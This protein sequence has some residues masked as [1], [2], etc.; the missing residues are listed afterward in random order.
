M[1]PSP[2]DAPDCGA[3]LRTKNKRRA[4]LFWIVVSIAVLAGIAFRFQHADRRQFRADESITA[5]RVSGHTKA[6]VRGLFDGHVYSQGAILRFQRVDPTRSPLATVWSIASEEPQITPLFFIVDREWA[7]VAGSSIASLRFPAVL[8]SIGAIAAMYWLCFELTGSYVVGGIG[9]ALMSL[10]P[11]FVNYGAQARQYSLWAALVALTSAALLAAF[12]KNSPR[13]WIFYSATMTLALYADAL[14]LFLL[15]AHTA[16][17]LCYHRDRRSLT[18]FGISA[19]IA[20]LFFLPW[21]LTILHGR[22]AV[23][24]DMG[25]MHLTVPLR[26]F[27]RAWAFNIAAVLFDAEW[28]NKWLFPFAIAALALLA[29]SVYRTQHDEERK[30]TWFLAAIAIGAVLP[31]L[32]LD[33]ATHSHGSTISRYLIPLWIAL[34][35]AVAL[36]LGRGLTKNAQALDAAWLV[37]FGTVLVIEG[38]S[39]AINSSAIVWWDNYDFESASIGRTIAASSSPLILSANDPNPLVLTLSHYVSPS[40]RF[41]LFMRSPPFPLHLVDDTFLLG[42]SESALSALREARYRVTRVPIPGGRMVALYRVSS[43]AKRN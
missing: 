7:A 21:M 5:L 10:S 25:W 41:L 34:L 30:K 36:L 9:A 6:E 23:A 39:C 32:L 35:V 40:T 17:I 28:G 22:G 19:C 18:A 12:R 24:S 43:T 3:S 31:Q 13:T 14:S 2:A 15:A 29:Y 8:F 37:A 38:V 42:P 4:R 27:V 26:N 33:F 1:K 20:V 16:Y 11:F